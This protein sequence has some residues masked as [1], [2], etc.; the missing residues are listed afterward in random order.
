MKV[1]VELIPKKWRL[2]KQVS[3][4]NWMDIYYDYLNFP[5]IAKEG[6][7]IPEEL[8]EILEKNY[9][10]KKKILHLRVQ[11][12]SNLRWALLRINKLLYDYKSDLELL[13]VT[14]DSK[15]DKKQILK[16]QNVLK[17]KNN[18]KISICVDNYKPFYGS[19]KRK[20]R[21]LNS[22]NKIFT[23]PIFNIKRIEE[24]VS[25]LKKEWFKLNNENLFVWITWF[26]SE[27]S[28]NYWHNVN[29]VPLEDLPNKNFLN[30][31]IARAVEVYKYA[32]QEGFSVYFMPIIQDLKDIVTIQNKAEK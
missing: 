25:F 28:K 23:Q 22:N 12:S 32:K 24:L 30:N 18:S 5:H 15:T 29:K 11:D 2:R 19:L 8:A 1:S 17:F 9:D 6:F 7:Y 20:L 21:Y 31:T 26:T 10:E 13:L 3:E 27:K 14:G 16:T 4:L